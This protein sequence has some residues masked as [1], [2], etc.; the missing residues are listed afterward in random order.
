VKVA[1]DAQCD[2]TLMYTKASPSE[3]FTGGF[4]ALGA[5]GSWNGILLCI[6]KV[7]L[8]SFQHGTVRK[9]GSY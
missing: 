7:S 8:Q 3:I 1:N 2:A 6:V 4:Q 9:N 5:G